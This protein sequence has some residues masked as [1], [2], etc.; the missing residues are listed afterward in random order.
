[1]R[2]CVVKTSV[3]TDN[4]GVL[5]HAVRCCHGRPPPLPLL[6]FFKTDNVGSLAVLLSAVKTPL[7]Y[8]QFWGLLNCQGPFLLPTILVSP[9]LTQCTI[10]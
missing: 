10:A 1:M 5:K 4:F 2:L 3:F 6:I 7:F 8:G 9:M